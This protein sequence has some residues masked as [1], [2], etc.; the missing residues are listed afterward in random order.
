MRLQAL[1]SIFALPLQNQ[2]TET[3]RQQAREETPERRAMRAL[4]ARMGELPPKLQMFMAGCP[5]ELDAKRHRIACRQLI[6]RNMLALSNGVR[7]TLYWNL[8]PEV[9]G[10]IDPYVIMHLLIGKLPLLDYRGGHLTHLYPEAT[11]FELLTSALEDAV[12]VVRVE[13]TDSTVFAFR[14]ERSHSEPVLVL[15]E[16]RDAFDGERTSSSTVTVPWWPSTARVVDAFGASQRCDASAGTLTVG[17]TE[18]PLFITVDGLR[19]SR[20][21]RNAS[22]PH[23]GAGAK[24]GAS[25]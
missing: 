14:V 21:A 19:R 15:W 9:P 12:N 11:A 20:D 4:Y 24:A 13:M 5:P 3:L 6:I 25:P 8:A 22:E 16:R 7:Q 17:L 18:T 23:A 2:S 1:A 10:P